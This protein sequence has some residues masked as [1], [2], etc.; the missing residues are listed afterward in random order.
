MQDDYFFT[1]MHTTLLNRTLFV[2]LAIRLHSSEY[3][4]L[5]QHMKR[6]LNSRAPMHQVLVE[7]LFSVSK[8]PRDEFQ[9]TYLFVTRE[10]Q[11]LQ[12]HARFATFRA[13]LGCKRG[14]RITKYDQESW[15]HRD[16]RSWCRS[17]Y[18]F[19]CR[20]YNLGCKTGVILELE[21]ALFHLCEAGWWTPWDFVNVKVM[22]Y[23]PF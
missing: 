7:S 2:K 22:R 13:T 12:N 11:K 8:W 4:P 14:Q 16:H 19:L 15:I 20:L 23:L 5:M 6:N 21:L 3:Q 10:L 17:H 18:Q 1:Y 9:R